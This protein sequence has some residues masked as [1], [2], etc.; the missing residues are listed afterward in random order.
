MDKFED[1]DILN[2][3][4][5]QFEK[6]WKKATKGELVKFAELLIEALRKRESDY[7][8]LRDARDTALIDLNRSREANEAVRKFAIEDQ[9]AKDRL[10]LAYSQLQHMYEQR[11]L[12]EG[13][14]SNSLRMI[15]EG[16]SR[17]RAILLDAINTTPELQKFIL[18]QVADILRDGVD[19]YFSDASTWRVIL[20]DCRGDGIRTPRIACI[21]V[22][23]EILHLDLR[24]AKEMTDPA[25]ETPP[26]SVVLAKDLDSV[27]AERWKRLLD[28]AAPTAKFTVTRG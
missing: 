9:E 10:S 18:R 20:H 25:Y 21:K 4:F 22:I 24:V 19:T 5:D 6:C 2:D 12:R 27:A 16:N 1:F 14:L 11:G 7:V 15:A 26:K 8:N 17:L 13:E 3:D 28:D 23:R